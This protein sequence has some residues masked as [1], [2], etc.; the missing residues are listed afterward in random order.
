[1]LLSH[2]A[3]SFPY[4]FFKASHWK[5][6]EACPKNGLPEG[7]AAGSF[8]FYM[9]HSDFKASRKDT[10]PIVLWLT[11]RELVQLERITFRAVRFYLGLLFFSL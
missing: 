10:N 2:N 9:D 3:W 7:K 8:C 5:V 11:V 6:R 4:R 1:M